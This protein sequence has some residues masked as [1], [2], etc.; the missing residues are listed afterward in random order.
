MSFSLYYQAKRDRPLTGE[1]E[2]AVA[3]IVRHS[4][5]QYPFKRKVED[6]GVYPA[7]GEE[8]VIFNGSTKLPG[9][10]PKVLY[11]T[12]NYWLKGLTQITRLLEGASWEVRFD[13]VDLILDPEEGWRFPTDEEYR[14][15]YGR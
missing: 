8:K 1:E 12:A 4:C 5:D 7:E 14:R 9:N 15:R 2:Q 10:G 3:E 6:F 11:D 13:D